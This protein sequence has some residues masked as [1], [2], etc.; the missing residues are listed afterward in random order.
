VFVGRAADLWSCYLSALG[1]GDLQALD[2]LFTPDAT[3]FSQLYGEIGAMEYHRTFLGDTSR[4]R[5]DM[6]SFYDGTPVGPGAAAHVRWELTLAD[7]ET[8]SI[9]AVDLV[10]LE[11]EHGRIQRLTF[12]YD[13]TEA[14]GA[15]EAM[16]RRQLEREVDAA[17]LANRP[18]PA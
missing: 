2:R 7:E 8:I 14:R 13:P 1:A 17:V 12:I 5:P 10:E 11:C 15:L 9:E 3:V 6:L 18:D 16:R 4:V